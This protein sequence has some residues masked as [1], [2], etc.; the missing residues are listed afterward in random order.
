MRSVVLPPFSWLPPDEEGYNLTNWR[1]NHLEVY[2]PE[3]EISNAKQS[4][5]VIPFGGRRDYDK[6]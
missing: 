2:V 1:E 6:K 4:E 3:G 5:A